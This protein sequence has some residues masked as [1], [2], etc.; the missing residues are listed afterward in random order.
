MTVHGITDS[1]AFEDVIRYVP[2]T[3]YR[4]EQGRKVLLR[5]LSTLSKEE[6]AESLTDALLWINIFHVDMTHL[7]VR[8]YGADYRIKDTKEYRTLR[9]FLYDVIG[10]RKENDIYNNIR[11]EC[12]TIRKMQREFRMEMQEK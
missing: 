2:P 12:R 8:K 11:D 9:M 6:L 5:T 7:N 10:K 4:T 1:K 3:D